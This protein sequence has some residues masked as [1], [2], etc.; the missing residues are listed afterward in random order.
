MSNGMGL[1]L[2]HGLA[3]EGLRTNDVGAKTKPRRGLSVGAPESS[4]LV[5]VEAAAFGGSCRAASPPSGMA[6]AEA[7]VE[8]LQD[9]ESDWPRAKPGLERGFPIA[10]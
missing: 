9:G 3:N 7:D 4:G 2:I 8:H 6:P 10:R 1:A 5:A